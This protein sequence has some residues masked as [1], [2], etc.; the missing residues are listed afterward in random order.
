MTD[1]LIAQLAQVSALKV[2]SRTSVMQYKSAP[3]SIPEVARELGVDAIVEGSVRR[4]GNRVRITAQLIEGATDHHLWAQSL[5]RDMGDVLSLQSEVARAL[6]QEIRVTVTPS[7]E[8]RLGRTR[9]VDPEAYQLYLKG[10][11]LDAADAGDLV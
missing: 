11:Y 5:D 10:N 8:A 7:E 1:E 6:V 4:S 3:K 2:I 9:S